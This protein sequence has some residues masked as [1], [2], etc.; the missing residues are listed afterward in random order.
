MRAPPGSL[1]GGRSTIAEKSQRSRGIIGPVIEGSFNVPG[2]DHPRSPRGRQAQTT[3][4]VRQPP[5]G[6]AGPQSLR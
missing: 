5:E 2:S 4:Q 3:M 6:I 1:S